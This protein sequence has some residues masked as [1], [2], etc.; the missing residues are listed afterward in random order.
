MT[1]KIISSLWAS[2]SLSDVGRS[3][4]FWVVLWCV[5]WSWQAAWS[6]DIYWLNTTECNC[7]RREERR[8]QC[9][10]K[11]VPPWG[12]AGPGDAL[13]SSPVSEE[14]LLSHWSDS[15]APGWRI[16]IA[17]F[18]GFCSKIKHNCSKLKFPTSLLQNIFY[19]SRTPPSRDT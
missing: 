13:T 1:P 6:P 5:A 8:P 10:G 15:K 9:L 3:P 12:P 16:H 7:P 2:L 4:P 19:I 17:G 11:S 14:H 18:H